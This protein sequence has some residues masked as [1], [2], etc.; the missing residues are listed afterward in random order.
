MIL[1]AYALAQVGTLVVKCRTRRALMQMRLDVSAI[2][3]WETVTNEKVGAPFWTVEVRFVRPHAEAEINGHVYRS[4]DTIQG[5][6]VKVDRITAHGV[7]VS[8]RNEV[9]DVPQSPSFRDHELWPSVH[10]AWKAET[11]S[12]APHRRALRTREPSGRREIPDE[13]TAP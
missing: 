7:Q 2:T 5:T 1:I 8:P 13:G 9:R 12:A 4:G 6:Q 11:E 10:A 3:L